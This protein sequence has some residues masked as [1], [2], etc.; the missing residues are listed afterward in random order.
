MKNIR[1]YI[2]F[3]VVLSQPIT[4]F[5]YAQGASTPPPL[6]DQEYLENK[7]R[8]KEVRN[9]VDERDCI[10]KLA[11]KYLDMEPGAH[12]DLKL[13]N[14]VYFRKDILEDTYTVYA[15][16]GKDSQEYKITISAK[17]NTENK[18]CSNLYQ[19]RLLDSK[20]EL[21]TYAETEAHHYFKVVEPTSTARAIYSP[22]DFN[23]ERKYRADQCPTSKNIQFDIDPELLSK[24]L[25]V[26]VGEAL[27]WKTSNKITK[28]NAGKWKL[29]RKFGK[30]FLIF[31][32]SGH[33]VNAYEVIEEGGK[34]KYIAVDANILARL[35]RTSS[36]LLIKASDK[37][38]T[39]GVLTDSTDPKIVLEEGLVQHQ[40]REETPSPSV[41]TSQADPSAEQK[42]LEADK[43]RRED[44]LR[45]L[46]G[47]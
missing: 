8:T 26:V 7:H 35:H 20:G 28:M 19:F 15:V 29:V 21:V 42:K 11:R 32:E 37:I 34:P 17:Y 40:K 39:T 33:V 41:H 31:E 4:T 14:K 1:V 9:A 38:C 27:L 43:K 44:A 18:S 16:S 47:D 12:K 46:K 22:T 36:E 3:L 45:K 6:T 13:E 24:D 30:A 10:L 5:G 23:R 25:P 2:L